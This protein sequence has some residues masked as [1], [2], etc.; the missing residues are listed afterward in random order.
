VN[1]DKVY[2]ASVDFQSPDGNTSTI[3]AYSSGGCSA[4]RNL[5]CTPLWIYHPANFESIQSN[6]TVA[7][8]VLYGSAVGFLW[9]FDANG[10][11]R[12]VCGFL[13]F[14]GL[15]T[16]S[17]TSA[18]PSVAGGVT[19]YTQNGGGIGGFDARGCGEISCAPL[20]STI[21]QPF[22]APMTT[23]VILDGRLYVA[24]P[25]VGQRPTMW[26]YHLPKN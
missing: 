14:G 25:A 10:C 21:T 1:G 19:Y 2:F 5:D 23:P 20:F 3:Y 9:A 17:G 24:G 4:T 22:E 12:P 6:L 7:G 18:S 26:V 15:G 16:T 13:W 11:G 8:G